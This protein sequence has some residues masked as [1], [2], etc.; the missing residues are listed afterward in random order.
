MRGDTQENSIRSQFTLFQRLV[1]RNKTWLPQHYLILSVNKEDIDERERLKF[2]LTKYWLPL[3]F[4]ASRSNCTVVYQSVG[5][6]LV[7]MDP[8]LMRRK[9]LRT[10]RS[11]LVRILSFVNSP[12]PLSQSHSLFLSFLL[13]HLLIPGSG[14]SKKPQPTGPVTFTLPVKRCVHCPL[15]TPNTWENSRLLHLRKKRSSKDLQKRNWDWVLSFWGIVATLLT[16]RSDVT[17]RCL[18]FSKEYYK[19][20]CFPSF[21]SDR[22]FN[23]K[24]FCCR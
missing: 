7:G 10:L 20:R 3:L 8:P 11:S 2:W 5:C 18:T 4:D 13:L 21:E 15:F 19:T 16:S 14:I 6:C 9:D 12:P 24:Y 23:F 1:W 17:V 22:P